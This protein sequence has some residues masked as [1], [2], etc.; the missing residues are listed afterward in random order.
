MKPLP[1]TTQ[2]QRQK[3][4]EKKKK[5][6]HFNILSVAV[7]QAVTGHI[8]YSKDILKEH[9]CELKKSFIA[10]QSSLFFFTF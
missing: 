7:H 6:A 2:S 8:K 5:T 9:F 3:K 10:G 4:K 1:L